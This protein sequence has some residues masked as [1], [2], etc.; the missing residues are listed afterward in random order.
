MNREPRSFIFNLGDGEIRW[1]GRIQPALSLEAFDRRDVIVR[2]QRAATF[3]ITHGRSVSRPDLAKLVHAQLVVEPLLFLEIRKF[4][5][6][7]DGVSG[8]Y[9]SLVRLGF[10]RTRCGHRCKHDC[11]SEGEDDPRQVSSMERVERFR[12]EHV[13]TLLSR[14]RSPRASCRSTRS[15]VSLDSV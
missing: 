7:S 14:E 4:F 11:D 10:D 6:D 9:G 8:S 12:L 3:S 1:E 15:G 5:G 2:L 13:D